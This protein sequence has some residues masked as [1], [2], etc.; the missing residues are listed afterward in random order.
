MSVVKL[1]EQARRHYQSVKYFQFGNTAG[2]SFV[3]TSDPFNY[4]Q[5]WL[6]NKINDIQR[7]TGTK[8]EKLYKAKYFTNLSED[9]FLSS[10]QSRMPSK[11]TLIYYSLLN[12][13]KVFLIIKGYDLESKTESHGLTLPANSETKLKLKSDSDNRSISIFHEFGKCLGK[14]ISNG[15]GINFEFESLLRDLPE[16]HEIGYALNIFPNSKRKFLPIELVIRTNDPKNKLYYTISFE[17]KNEK[18]M[19][20]DK[21]NRSNFKEKLNQVEIEDTR[22]NCY[23]S[24]FKINYTKNSDKSWEMAYKKIVKDISE[25]NITTLLTRNGYRN[26]LNLEP[27]RFHRLSSTL[28]FAYYIGTVARYRPT[29]NEKVLKGQYQ[30]LIS[31]AIISCP[32]Q[33]FY[34]LVSYITNQVCA[35]PQAKID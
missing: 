22:L 7:D 20:T 34:Q 10:K 29:L 12:L 26:Y 9:F 30:A 24:V 23:Q 21:L 33:F 18:L 27:T 19:S 15:D 11:G 31:E 4:L 35:V 3:L 17:K 6:D 2:S 8:R 25:L 16:I 13:V 28:A 14:P 1:G 5:S 32:N